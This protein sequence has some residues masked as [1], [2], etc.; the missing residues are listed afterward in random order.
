M[1]LLPCMPH[2]LSQRSRTHGNALLKYDEEKLITNILDEPPFS[3]V[4]HYEIAKTVG[5]EVDL[6]LFM[7]TM[8]ILNRNSSNSS[9]MHNIDPRDQSVLPLPTKASTTI[10]DAL[11]RT[12][13]D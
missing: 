4:V 11:C 9:Q 10:N 3:F 6:I 13:D 7:A 1:I 8:L 5:K 2:K 12:L